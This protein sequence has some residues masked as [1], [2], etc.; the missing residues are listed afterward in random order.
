VR[1]IIRKAAQVSGVVLLATACNGG[2]AGK[3]TF[4]GAGTDVVSATAKGIGFSVPTFPFLSGPTHPDRLTRIDSP[5]PA[6][7]T[8][9]S[10]GRG[11]VAVGDHF[12]VV[13]DQASC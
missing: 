9:V 7:P 13:G 1:S 4:H 2:T 10:P 5:G 8:P 12:E 11:E 3:V 6:I